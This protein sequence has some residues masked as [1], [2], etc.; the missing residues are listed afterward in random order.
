MYDYEDMIG[1]YYSNIDL[2]WLVLFTMLL[3]LALIIII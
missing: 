3:F 2:F 1:E